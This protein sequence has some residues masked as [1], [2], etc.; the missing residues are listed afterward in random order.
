MA[1]NDLAWLLH[2]KGEYEEARTLIDEAIGMSEKEYSLWDTKGVILL[3]MEEY[4]VRWPS[5]T[6]FHR[7]IYTWAR[8][9]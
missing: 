9:S 8:P 2:L 3:R 5:S 4:D 6:R 1:L 7:Y